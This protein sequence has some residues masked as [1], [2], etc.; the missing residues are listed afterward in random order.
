MDPSNPP[1]QQHA[2]QGAPPPAPDPAPAPRKVSRKTAWIRI[3]ILL[4]VVAGGLIFAYVKSQS[5]PGN[6]QVGDCVQANGED[7]DSVKKVACTDPAAAYKVAGKVPDK[8]Q[9]EA[10]IAVSSVCDAF[11]TADHIFWQGTQGEKGTALCLE[12]VTH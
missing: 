4:V 6:A 5:N 9:I 2:P 8:T 7:A 1:Q 12:P 10:S 11:P 3:G